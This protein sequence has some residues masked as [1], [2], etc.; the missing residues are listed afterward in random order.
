MATLLVRWQLSTARSR[1]CREDLLNTIDQ[2]G[3][4]VRLPSR[5]MMGTDE[6]AKHIAIRGEVASRGVKKAYEQLGVEGLKDEKRL[7]TFIEDQ[8]AAAFRPDAPNARDK[9]AVDASYEYALEVRKVANE[10]TFQEQNGWADVITGITTQVPMI[11]P[12]VPFVRT[13]KHHQAGLH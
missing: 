11:K 2:T 8:Y 5:L 4:F 6:F 9:W 12:F 1:C 7:K 3:R 13:L 10:V